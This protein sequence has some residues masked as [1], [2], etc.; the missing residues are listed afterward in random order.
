MCYY[1]L[2]NL[3]TFERI[4]KCFFYVISKLLVL[5]V[6]KRLNRRNKQYIIQAI[7]DTVLRNSIHRQFH[8][9]LPS[10]FRITIHPPFF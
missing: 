6:N 9:R 5:S 7:K 2:I 3:K 10:R 4:N 8:V 1:F